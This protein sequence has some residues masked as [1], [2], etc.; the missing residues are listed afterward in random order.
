M[1]LSLKLPL[2]ILCSG[3]ASK[4]ALDISLL[5]TQLEAVLMNALELLIIL[6]NSPIKPAFSNVMHLSLHGQI[7]LLVS[8]LRSALQA[9]MLTI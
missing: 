1:Q 5:I 6:V 8:A 9:R 4:S 3:S 2:E 7:M